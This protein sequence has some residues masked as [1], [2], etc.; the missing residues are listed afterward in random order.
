MPRATVA[1]ALLGSARMTIAALVL[2]LDPLLRVPTL[3]KLAALP[4]LTLGDP[5]GV[6]L[7]AVLEAPDQKTGGRLLDELEA[8]AGIVAVEL[9]SAHFAEDLANDTDR[10]A[11]D[12]PS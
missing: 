9:V 6:R 8:H 11:T 2:V 5:A 1:C 7:P 12:E 10:E 3:A 4:Y